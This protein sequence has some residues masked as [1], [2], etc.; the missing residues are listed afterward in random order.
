MVDTNAQDVP[1]VRHVLRLHVEIAVNSLAANFHFDGCP[2]F[3]L[4]FNVVGQRDILYTVH[5]L[6]LRRVESR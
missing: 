4:R 2:I 3:E 1:T 6:V 5:C